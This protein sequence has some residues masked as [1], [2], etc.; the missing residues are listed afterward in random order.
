M[1][2]T[3]AKVSSVFVC[4]KWAIQEKEIK[5]SAIY[6]SINKHFRIHLSKEIKDPYTKN[7]K[8]TK[9]EHQRIQING[10]QHTK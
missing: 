2:N 3:H 9:D 4:E 5:T 8:T 10:N 1:R 7:Y 6:N